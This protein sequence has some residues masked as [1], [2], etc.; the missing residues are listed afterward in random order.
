MLKRNEIRVQCAF[1]WTIRAPKCS[2][3]SAARQEV[4]LYF[5][6]RS[7]ALVWVRRIIYKFEA[8]ERTRSQKA[9]SLSEAKTF[10]YQCDYS[11]NFILLTAWL[12]ESEKHL[13]ATLLT[14]DNT[15]CRIR[16]WNRATKAVFSSVQF[17]LFFGFSFFVFGGFHPKNKFGLTRTRPRR[18]RRK[19]EATSTFLIPFSSERRNFLF[20]AWRFVWVSRVTNYSAMGSRFERIRAQLWWLMANSSLPPAHHFLKRVD[21]SPPSFGVSEKSH[22]LCV[23]FTNPLVALIGGET[24]EHLISF[25]AFFS[26]LLTAQTMSE[27]RSNC[28]QCQLTRLDYTRRL[29]ICRGQTRL[30]CWNETQAWRF[31]NET[32]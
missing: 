7:R 15:L 28:E 10:R 12:A 4:D 32:Q 23:G 26:P 17:F 2:F 21:A 11:G 1:V 20:G 13:Q 14:S 16:D 18:A 31:L 27:P 3:K 6:S 22:I 19:Q 9:L 25:Q 8:K 30:L 29:S 24:R 5:V